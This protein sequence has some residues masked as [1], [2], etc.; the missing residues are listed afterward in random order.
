MTFAR[1]W[2]R[3]TLAGSVGMVL[4]SVGGS[5][6]KNLGYW[7][8]RCHHG[9]MVLTRCTLLPELSSIARTGFAAIPAECSLPSSQI[10]K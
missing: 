6:I 7:L 10:A 4:R 1:V 5:S 3:R 8:E 9:A 2:K